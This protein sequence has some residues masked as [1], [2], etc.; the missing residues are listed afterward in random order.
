MKSVDQ[1]NRSARQE[2]KQE[3]LSSNIQGKT[4]FSEL[5]ISH[6][7]ALQVRSI[8]DSGNFIVRR[9]AIS[10]YGFANRSKFNPREN[11]GVT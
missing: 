5:G 6:S 3:P 9:G 10:P 2:E 8:I 1:V 11:R 4:S 7:Q